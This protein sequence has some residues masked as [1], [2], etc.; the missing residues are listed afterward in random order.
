[1]VVNYSAIK[2]A[3]NSLYGLDPRF[4]K[5]ATQCSSMRH[6]QIRTE[7]LHPLSIPK[8]S[9]EESGWES[10]LEPIKHGIG[11]LGFVDYNN[12]LLG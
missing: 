8:E 12:A 7:R 9:G 10:E 5:P 11:N 3:R 2:Y 1:M 4:E 6:A